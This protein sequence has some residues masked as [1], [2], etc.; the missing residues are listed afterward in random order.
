M[1]LE[2][3]IPM[4]KNPFGAFLG[5][6]FPVSFTLR[7]VQDIISDPFKIKADDRQPAQGIVREGKV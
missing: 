1:P 3:T 5:L 6:S 7:T 2:E 4:M